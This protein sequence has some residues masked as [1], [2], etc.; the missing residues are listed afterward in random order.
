MSGAR[1][2][3]PVRIRQSSVDPAFQFDDEPEALESGAIGVSR[4]SR[5]EDVERVTGQR[6]A[7]V[8]L[9]IGDAAPDFSSSCPSPAD[10]ERLHTAFGSPTS[11]RKN[12]GQ[13]EHISSSAL[14]RFTPP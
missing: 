8:I 5:I 13:A 9:L 10:T 7:A 1:F 6:G 11:P 2:N 12:G 14:C 3:G 4:G